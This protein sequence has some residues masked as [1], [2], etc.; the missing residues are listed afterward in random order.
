MKTCEDKRR[1][2]RFCHAVQAADNY[3]E[4]IALVLT[5]MVPYRCATHRCYHIGHNRWMIESDIRT[6]TDASRKR[7]RRRHGKGPGHSGPIERPDRTTS[8]ETLA[9]PRRVI[10]CLTEILTPHTPTMQIS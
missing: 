6:F 7:V 5:P 1:F 9:I 2:K 8:Q 10:R 3:M 4:E